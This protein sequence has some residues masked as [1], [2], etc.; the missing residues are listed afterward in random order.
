MDA[1]R[2]SWGGA[3]VKEGLDPPRRTRRG[4][5]GRVTGALLLLCWVAEE[6]LGESV[7]RLGSEV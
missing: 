7:W 3:V 2:G 6:L 1:G 5:A 4:P